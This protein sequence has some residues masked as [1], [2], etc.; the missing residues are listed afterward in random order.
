META[1]LILFLPSGVI[2]GVKSPYK[3]K[4]Y[5]PENET[6]ALDVFSAIFHL[7]KIAAPIFQ[8]IFETR[9]STLSSTKVLN[10]GVRSFYFL[11]LMSKRDGEERGCIRSELDERK[12]G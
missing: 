5:S 8:I 6:C 2:N 9:P 1:S 7:N 10:E 4:N 11:A 3:K 12:L